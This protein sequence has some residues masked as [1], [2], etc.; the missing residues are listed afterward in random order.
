M[1]KAIIPKQVSHFLKKKEPV[2]FF[3]VP[4]FVRMNMVGSGLAFCLSQ[5]SHTNAL[6]FHCKDESDIDISYPQYEILPRCPSH[7]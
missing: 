6:K 3:Y 1:S 2:P 5:K 7:L 4:F